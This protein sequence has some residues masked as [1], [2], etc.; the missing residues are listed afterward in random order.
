MVPHGSLG[1]ILG[2]GAF[3][4]AL[5]TPGWAGVPPSMSHLCIYTNTALIRCPGLPTDSPVMSPHGP[6]CRRCSTNKY[7][8]QMKKGGSEKEIDLPKDT[9][10]GSEGNPK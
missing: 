6:Q 3:Y 1:K 2:R 5:L 10:L 9:E 8:S 7:V 4:G